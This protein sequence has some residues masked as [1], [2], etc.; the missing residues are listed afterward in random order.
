MFM[1]PPE[2]GMDLVITHS[3]SWSLT[4]GFDFEILKGNLMFFLQ[5]DLRSSFVTFLA[6]L[7]M[8]VKLS[9]RRFG[10]PELSL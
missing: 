1:T 6:I 5:R 9:A 2:T 4:D 8:R 3:E 7:L 10:I